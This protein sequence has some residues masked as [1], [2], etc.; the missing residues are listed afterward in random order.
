MLGNLLRISLLIAIVV[1]GYRV[2]WLQSDAKHF[3]DEARK[4]EFTIRTMLGSDPDNVLIRQISFDQNYSL[5]A[6]SAP[7]G[8]A[9][10]VQ[11]QFDA[12][13]QLQTETL[14]Y[15]PSRSTAYDGTIELEFDLDPTPP[16]LASRKLQVFGPEFRS[17][18]LSAPPTEKFNN[19]LFVNQIL[20]R[21]TSYFEKQSEYPSRNRRSVLQV[22]NGMVLRDEI[23]LS[24][25]SRK[26]IGKDQF[27]LCSFDQME[28]TGA[29]LKHISKLIRVVVVD[30]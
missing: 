5:W 18:L 10:E 21:E 26:F 11:L 8:K 28:D 1:G 14:M 25:E 9:V 29:K 13:G 2:Y 6:Y 23:Q 7:P 27:V 3:E 16:M 17:A 15:I 12:D 30:E 20:P 24:K 22:I 19:I 4:L